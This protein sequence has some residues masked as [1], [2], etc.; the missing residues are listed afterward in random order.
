MSSGT[1]GSV[2]RG[3]LGTGVLRSCEQGER[4]THLKKASQTPANN[5]SKRN[6]VVMQEADKLYGSDGCPEPQRKVARQVAAI[7]TSIEVEP[8]TR[9]GKHNLSRQLAD[10]PS[11]TNSLSPFT[12]NPGHHHAS[13]ASELAEGRR[14]AEHLLML[15]S[16]AEQPVNTLATQVNTPGRSHSPSDLCTSDL[17][18]DIQVPTAEEVE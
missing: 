15:V 6:L 7:N 1:Q 14:S 3:N 8:D 4:E 16:W 10:R 17:C 13:A 9:D 12:P 11:L 18:A 5:S 2:P